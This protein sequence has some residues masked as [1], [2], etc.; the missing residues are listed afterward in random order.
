MRQLTK[1]LATLGPSCD[2]P[3]RLTKLVGYG[4]RAVRLNFSHGSYESKADLIGV[5]RQVEAETQKPLAILGDLSGPKVRVGTVAEKTVLTVGDSFRILKEPVVGD[6][7]QV[8]CSLPQ[9]LDDVRVGEPVL[10]NDGRIQ[11]TVTGVSPGVVECRVDVGGPLS[12]RKGLNLPQTDLSLSALT[13]KDR[14][15]AA[16]IAGND[17]D[18]VALSFVQ[19]RQDIEELRALLFGLDCR[20]PIMAKIEKP[21]AVQRI[22]EIIQASDAVMVARGDLA[23][24]MDFPQV[25]VAQKRIARKAALRGKPCVIATEMM[26]S[27]VHSPTPTR[28]EVSDVANA[29]LDGADAVMLSA[30]TAVGEYPVETVS[31]MGRTIREVLRHPDIQPPAPDG[32]SERLSVSAAVKAMIDAEDVAVAAAYSASGRTVRL[33]S[34]TQPPCAILALSSDVRVCRQM[35]LYRGV[36]P[37]VCEPPKD[38]DEIVRRACE[39]AKA[40]GLAKSGEKL[41]LVSSRTSAVPGSRDGLILQKLS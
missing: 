41:M 15:D 7:R 13:E 17:V 36:V 4:V 11:L 37:A 19:R 33:L 9:L 26:E 3:E 22:D 35:A 40:R 34:K 32:T 29:V 20:L 30:E 38:I 14:E 10:I 8:S 27:M 18:Y 16:W 2:T 12:S 31:M 25:P 23:V 5:V 1:I 24:E 6:A 21:L 28:A 39:I